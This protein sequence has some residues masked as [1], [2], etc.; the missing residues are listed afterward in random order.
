LL[1]SP[2][3]E[4]K[5]AK[6]VSCGARHSAILTEDGQLFSWGWNKYGQLGLGDSVDR[7]TPYRVTVTGVPKNV[8]CG[9]WHTLLLA[10]LPI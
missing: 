5:Q 2:G 4:G 3:L 8:A 6:L 7:S 9:W 10:E 1:D